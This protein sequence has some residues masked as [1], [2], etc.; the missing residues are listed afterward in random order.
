MLKTFW[1]AAVP[2][3][4]T[5]A[6]AGDATAVETRFP[7]A[8]CRLLNT[9]NY[10][11]T[12]AYYRTALCNYTGQSAIASCTFHMDSSIAHSYLTVYGNTNM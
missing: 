8:T 9:Y 2:L 4:V 11:T 1:K 3:A 6:F 7:G 12:G 5:L 10:T